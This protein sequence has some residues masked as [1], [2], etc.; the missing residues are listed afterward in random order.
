MAKIE[1]LAIKIEQSYEVMQNL[2]E[3]L[4]SLHKMADEIEQATKVMNSK[5][6]SVLDSKKFD[7][8][9]DQNKASLDKIMDD[10]AKIERSLDSI[11]VIRTLT[12]ETI[13][14]FSERMASMD[15]S[16]K[17]TKQTANDIDSKLLSLLKNAEKQMQAGENRIAK[18]SQ[19]FDVSAEIEKYDN[20][21][22]LQ[23]ENNQLLKE[24]HKAVIKDQLRNDRSFLKDNTAV[25]SVPDVTQVKRT[26][27]NPPKIDGQKT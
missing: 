10:V 24:I 1:E 21:I 18:A 14:K 22:K 19:L 15:E 8:I 20:L 11:D 27:E 16:F 7:G 5:F 13:S 23:K 4:G 26:M 2:M 6:L 9:R 3:E 12:Q 17:K 25:K